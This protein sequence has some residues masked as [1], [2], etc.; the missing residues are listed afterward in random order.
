MMPLLQK[1][2]PEYF[3]Y[4][5]CDTIIPYNERGEML[6]DAMKFVDYAMLEGDYLEFGVYQGKDFTSAYHLAQKCG[7]HNMMFYAF[8]SFGGLPK[9][10]GIDAKEPS[11]FYEG[12]YSC[13]EKE[14]KR[15]IGNKGVDLNKVKI[16]KG[17]YRDT[18]NAATKQSLPLK[19]AAIVWIDCDLYDSAVSVLDF[20][21][22]YIQNGTLLIFDDWFCFKGDPDMGEQLAFKQ[23]L[24]KNP[25]ITASEYHKFFWGGNS[26]ILHKRS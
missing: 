22:S 4:S 7:L 14:F 17:W 25:D 9:L 19:K 15:I 11:C 18:L 21:T 12:Q 8:D 23:W 13:S 10:K 3:R 16:V 1:V 26:F 2:L 20:I 24:G 5:V 6:K